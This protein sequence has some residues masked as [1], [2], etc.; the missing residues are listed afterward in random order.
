VVFPDSNGSYEEREA[1]SWMYENMQF[2]ATTE[3][4]PRKDDSLLMVEKD[5]SD[6]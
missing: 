4:K 6:F 5:F 2:E 3:L 1:L